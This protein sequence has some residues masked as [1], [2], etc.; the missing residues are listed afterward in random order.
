MEFFDPWYGYLWINNGWSSVM[1]FPFNGQSFH[2]IEGALEFL[3]NQTIFRFTTYQGKLEYRQVLHLANAPFHKRNN[4]SNLISES[5]N[6]L[7]H[8][9]MY[10]AEAGRLH[11][12]E[13]VRKF[14]PESLNSY[15]L[16]PEMFEGHRIF[17][18]RKCR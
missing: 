5:L 14:V 12:T 4:T 15:V 17:P 3:L 11:I 8:M 10:H 6:D 2:V 1:L 9:G 13:E 16:E 18:F 7:F